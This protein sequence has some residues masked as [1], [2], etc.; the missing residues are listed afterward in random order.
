MAAVRRMWHIQGTNKSSEGEPVFLR[1]QTAF[2][3]KTP[4]KL[5]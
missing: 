3:Q 1:S 5:I 4:Q 2:K